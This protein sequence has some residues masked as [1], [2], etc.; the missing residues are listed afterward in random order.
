MSILLLII[1]YLIFISL[2][3]PDPFISSAWPTVSQLFEVSKDSQ[4]ILTILLSIF[5]ILA[6]FFTLKINKWLKPFG[7]VVVSIALTAGGILMMSFANSFLIL[8]LACIPLGLGAG[9]IDCTLNNY[10][11]VNYKSIH[12]NWL[13]AF[14]GLGT[15]ITPLIIGGYISNP[16]GWRDAGVILAIIQGIILVITLCSAPVWFKV[17]KFFASRNKNEETSKTEEINL[18]FFKTFKLKGV[19][20]AILGFFCYCVVEQTSYIW[21]SSMLV[22]DMNVSETTA[23]SWVSLFFIGLVVGRFISGIVS[24]K[25]ND[26]IMIRIGEG[27]TLIGVILLMF[28][29]EVNIMPVAITII[30]FGNAPIYPSIIHDTPN[31]FTPKYSASVMS[32]QVGCAYASNITI[33][34]LF[35]VIAERTTFLILPYVVLLFTIIM[36]I[37]NEVT[38]IKTKDKTKL[39]KISK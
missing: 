26:K 18:G 20:F 37:C 5:T 9:A 14:W 3:V 1:I 15:I 21:F 28:S 27:I 12:L 17:D 38:T 16:N 2:G 11:A 6:S 4:G 7:T 29:F 33:V 31:R 8:C 23:A 22:F 24:I 32:I 34:P 25:L 36:I 39:L 10:V 13:H 35:G 30:G 19:I